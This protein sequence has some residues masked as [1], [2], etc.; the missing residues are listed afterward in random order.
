VAKEAQPQVRNLSQGFTVV[1][2]SALDKLYAEKVGTGRW[3]GKRINPVVQG[4][5]LSTLLWTEG[6]RHIPLGL[7][8]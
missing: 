3:S 6:D 4:I 8:V 1:D 5:S 7:S 2:D